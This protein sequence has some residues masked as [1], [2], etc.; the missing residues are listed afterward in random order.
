MSS[1]S[2]RGILSGCVIGLILILSACG[3]SSSGAQTS[4]L[5]Q[6]LQSKVLTVGTL[7]GNAPFESINSSGKL[8]GFDIDVANLLATELGVKANFIQTDIAG[9][10]TGLEDGKFDIVVGSFTETVPRAEVVY[11]TNPINT[12]TTTL[13]VTSSSPLTQLSQFNSPNVTIAVTAGGTNAQS[14]AETLPLAKTI[15]LPT[16]GDITEAVTSGNATAATVANTQ[17]PALEAADPGKFKSIQGTVGPTEYDC[18]GVPLGDFTWDNFVNSFVE[19]ENL[20]GSIY[21]LY[22][23]WFGPGTNPDTGAQPP[24][25]GT[26]S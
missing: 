23:K 4:I 1:I 11:F 18:I 22:Q 26:S 6:V 15:S 24:P 10:I 25:A 12:E 21:T 2:R 16:I 13:L 3:G 8:V 7:T 17:L 14:V 5:N 19:Q 9:R 20:N